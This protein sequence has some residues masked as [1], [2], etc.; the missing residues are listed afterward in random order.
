MIEK[1]KGKKK[2]RKAKKICYIYYICIHIQVHRCRDTIIKR[3]RLAGARNYNLAK[4]ETV[5]GDEI[6]RLI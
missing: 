1:N 4:A 3:V 2:I 5:H 6:L